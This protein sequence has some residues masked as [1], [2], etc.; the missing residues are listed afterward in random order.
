MHELLNRSATE[1][2]RAIRDREVSSKE[3]T[4]AALERIN[5]VNPKLNAVVVLAHDRALDEARARDA[6]TARRESKGPLPMTS[7]TGV[8]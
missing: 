8:P 4:R 3:I 5:E 7:P 6:E 1:I 2:A